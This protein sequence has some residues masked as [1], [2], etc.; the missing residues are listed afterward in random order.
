MI[1]TCLVTGGCGFIGTNLINKISGQI[2]NIRVID[3]LS[4]GRY[5]NIEQFGAEF[6]KGDIR[7]SGLIEKCL[8][9]VELV[10]HLA[11]HTG[12]V[13]SVEDPSSDFEV[14]A[15]STFNL[16]NLSKRHGVKKVIFASTGGAILGERTPPIHEGMV[17][18]PISPYGASKLAAEA[19]CLAFWGSY[20]LKT[21]IL[22]FSNVYGQYSNNK[23]S[24]V[25]QFM[26][27]I[28]ANKTLAVYGDGKQTRDFLFAEDLVS[29]VLSAVG[30]NGEA[31]VFQIASGKEVSILELVDMLKKV[32]GRP[33]LK[34]HFKP[35]RQGE[36][37]RNFSKID[38]AKKILNY[39]PVVDLETGLRKTWEWF[40][41]SKSQDLETAKIKR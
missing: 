34:I 16:L 4:V 12:V 29:A 3:N 37:R 6:I 39:K 23:S 38:K 9:G 8:Q 31:D 28:L 18:K 7:D 36:V 22:R 10:I 15:A 26:K 19:Y 2:P 5:E 17:P 1:K 41:K 32:C 25:A 33:D 13:N 40:L 27:D 14:N 30:F 21:T 35:A 11:A 24:V 20:G